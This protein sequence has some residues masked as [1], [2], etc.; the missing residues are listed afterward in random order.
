MGFVYI[1][2]PG[3]KMPDYVRTLSN[4]KKLTFKH[5]KHDRHLP[6]KDPRRATK[7]VE[8]AVDYLPGTELILTTQEEFDA[9]C[10]NFLV[11]KYLNIEKDTTIWVWDLW[12]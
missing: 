8:S 1:K 12:M 4:G 3:G 9:F 6:P 5:G 11:G 7:I 10:E 2:E